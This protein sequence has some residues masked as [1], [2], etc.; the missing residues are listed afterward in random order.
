VITRNSLISGDL[1]TSVIQGP[2]GLIS[3]FI[4]GILWGLLIRYVPER[5]DVSYSLCLKYRALL[6]V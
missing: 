1:F 2:I 3:G 5:H 4:F 6:L